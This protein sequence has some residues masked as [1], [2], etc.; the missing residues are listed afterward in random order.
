MATSPVMVKGPAGQYTSDLLKACEDNFSRVYP[1]CENSSD[2]GPIM[3]PAAFPFGYVAPRGEA[4]GATPLNDIE[5]GTFNGDAAEL[6]IFEALETF[7]GKTKQPMF[8]LTKFKFKDFTE[9]VLQK[10]L[11]AD[12]PTLVKFQHLQGELDFVI[13]HRR[14]GVILIE[15]K[16]MSE[17]IKQEYRR[18]KKQLNNG[19]EIVQALLHGIEI[20]V[21]V[22][23]VIALPNVSDR[24]RVTSGFIN[25]RTFN[26][27][28]Y[29]DFQ[30][31]WTTNFVDPEVE[32]GSSEQLKMQKLIAILVGQRCA[33]SSPAKVL[34]DVFKKIDTQSCLQRSF[35]KRD[36]VDEP[37]VVRK[38]N[39]PELTILA[40]QFMFLN[41]EQQCIWNGP[42]HQF[43][44]GV[45]GSG[46]TILLQFKALECAKKGEK[47]FVIVPSRLIKLYKNFFKINNVLSKIAVLP[48][49]SVLWKVSWRNVSE[50]C[51][52]FVDEWQLLWGKVPQWSGI[53][54]ALHDLITLTKQDSC[55]CWIT[56]DDKQWS[57]EP[58]SV[59][60]LVFIYNIQYSIH[61][62][63]CNNAF[64]HAASLTTNMRSTIQVF[65]YWNIASR[66]DTSLNRS[67]ACFPLDKYW[68][69]PVYLGHHICGPSVTEIDIPYTSSKD[70][71]RQVIK[72]EIESWAK[73]GEVYTFH[74]V[75]ILVKP[76]GLYSLLS[77]VLRKEHIP[78]CEAGDN[79]NGVVLE[80]GDS[81]HSYEWPV[82]IT[83]IC[84]GNAPELN[85]LMFSRAVTRLVVLYMD[86]IFLPFMLIPDDTF[87]FPF[88]LIPDEL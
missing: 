59:N 17:F 64:Y 26:V 28:S 73:D 19:E 83:A 38:T 2:H 52:V 22:H 58:D 75:A 87:L 8:V 31:W 34:S 72:H 40:K 79:C 47:A 78:V 5:E 62:Y 50:K 70:M 88:M 77:S 85:Y 82:V 61:T 24:G 68:S 74:K 65:S 30:C 15:V 3:C 71:L 44:C 21:P 14:I 56:Y 57:Y 12:H 49:E 51:H 66:G 10:I 32:F 84:T 1:E 53:S 36:T 67:H 7:G 20:N 35:D 33:V 4:S 55:Y 43:F 6:K 54:R 39:E 25:L 80:A 86:D 69:Y 81:I 16:A 18:A 45:A 37:N 29:E 23:K 41:R 11:P 63:F 46:K 9:Q 60:D 13:V 48:H 27:G 76:A 42:R